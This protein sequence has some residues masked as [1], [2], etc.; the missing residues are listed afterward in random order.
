MNATVGMFSVLFLLC[1]TAPSS[2]AFI[3]DF[4][5][6]N[7]DGWKVQ[8]ANWEVKNG[9]LKYKGGSGICGTSLYYKDGVE[10]TDYEFEVDMKLTTHNDWLSGIR[11]RLNPDT[12][13]SS[14]TWVYPVQTAI[15]VYIADSW[16]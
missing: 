12:G 6:G 1:V 11:V 16:D 8:S 4:D 2:R 3:D 7:L 10:W 15:M 9:E 13:E 5:D 14:F